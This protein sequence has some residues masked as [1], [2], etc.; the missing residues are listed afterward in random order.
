MISVKELRQKNSQEL[1]TFLREARRELAELSGKAA[2]K[3]LKD[4]RAVR[5]LKRE[6]A[7]GLTVLREKSIGR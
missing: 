5:R 6:V 7:R 2:L 1:T 4:V 3:Q